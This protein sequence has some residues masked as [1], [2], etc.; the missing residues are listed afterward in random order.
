MIAVSCQAAA[1]KLAA[2]GYV[3]LCGT[4][5]SVEQRSAGAPRECLSLPSLSAGQSPRQGAE[6]TWEANQH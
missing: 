6:R 5:I 3:S 2:K 1:G 4:K